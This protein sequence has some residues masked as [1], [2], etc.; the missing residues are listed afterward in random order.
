MLLWRF[1]IQGHSMEPNIKN[2]SQ[3]LTSSIPFIFSKPKIGNVVAF[4]KG[5]KVFIKRIKK[6]ENNKYFAAGDNQKD[7][8]DLWIKKDDIIGKVIINL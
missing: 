1:K 7:S 4:N 3:V 6:I 2:G 5:N 8:V